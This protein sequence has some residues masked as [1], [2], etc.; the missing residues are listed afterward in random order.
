MSPHLVVAAVA[1]VGRFWTQSHV[2]ALNVASVS[3]DY[4]V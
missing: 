3:G 1:S 4:G 2:A